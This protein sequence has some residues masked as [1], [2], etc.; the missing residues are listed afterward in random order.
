MFLGFIVNLNIS[1]N[2]IETLEGLQ[3]LDLPFLK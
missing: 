3:K 1:D 2:Q